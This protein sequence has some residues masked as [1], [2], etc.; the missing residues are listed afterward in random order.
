M[1]YSIHFSLFHSTSMQGRNALE[2][3][4]HFIMI[5]HYDF[6]HAA[7]ENSI[8][9]IKITHLTFII[10]ADVDEM[11]LTHPSAPS[12]SPYFTLSPHRKPNALHP[13]FAWANV[14]AD[15]QVFCDVMAIGQSLK[16]I[17]LRFL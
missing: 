11:I 16:K 2:I 12:L 4:F 8:L 17:S 3:T 9:C 7:K 14:W 1:P 15:L 13:P 5:M 10:P 6:N